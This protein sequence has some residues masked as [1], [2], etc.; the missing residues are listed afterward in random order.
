MSQT[1]VRT[2]P[3]SDRA[4]RS[5]V[6]SKTGQRLSIERAAVGDVFPMTFPRHLLLPPGI[7]PFLLRLSMSLVSFQGKVDFACKN[8][9]SAWVI[10]ETRHA[11]SCV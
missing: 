4:K 11:S 5:W 1:I 9:S 8:L 7:T 2:L 10:S 3:K 6:L